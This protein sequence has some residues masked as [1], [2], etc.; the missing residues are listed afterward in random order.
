MAGSA[1][2]GERGW[3]LDAHVAVHVWL[4]TY[5]VPRQEPVMA[6]YR[7]RSGRRIIESAAGVSLTDDE[8]LPPGR[9]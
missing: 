2:S 7:D 1:F 3:Y 5:E 6:W 4:T 8:D 9:R